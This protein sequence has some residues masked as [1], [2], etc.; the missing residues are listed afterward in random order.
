MNTIWL[1]AS[2]NIA[3]FLLH[4]TP[5]PRLHFFRYQPCSA[6]PHKKNI[7]CNTFNATGDSIEGYESSLSSTRTFNAV[8]QANAEACMLISDHGLM[9]I[10]NE[11][12]SCLEGLTL[13]TEE[14]EESKEN[15]DDLV[16]EHQQYLNQVED[17]DD[18]ENSDED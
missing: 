3:R 10:L 2:F 13:D 12:R 8:V 9:E 14:E 7:T 5:F 11:Q 6:A 18:E 15:L 16:L 17:D 4:A 1:D